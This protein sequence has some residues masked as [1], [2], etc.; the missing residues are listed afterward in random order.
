MTVLWYVPTR[1]M[2]G[3]PLVAPVYW[4]ADLSLI[5]RALSGDRDYRLCTG[6]LGVDHILYP[7]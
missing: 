5:R 4:L 6:I 2:I 1:R 3:F 7:S